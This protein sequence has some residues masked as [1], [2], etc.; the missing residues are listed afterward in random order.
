MKT[1]WQ[2]GKD[3][4]FNKEFIVFVCIG[5]FNTFNG[6]IFSY[7]YSNSIP[8]VN[9]AFVA[10]YLTSL[11]IAYLLN[12][13]FAFREKLS[14]QKF[15]KFVIS[16]IPNFLIQNAMVF[17]FYNTLHWNKLIT[18]FMAAAIGVPVTFIILKLFAFQKLDKK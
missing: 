16:Y 18:Y 13:L 14:L 9:L 2:K 6:S 11:I 15:F 3:L 12:S 1:I 10:G 7:I 4:F 8:N 17:L 5:V